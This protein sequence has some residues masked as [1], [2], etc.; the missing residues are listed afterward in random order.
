MTHGFVNTKT[1]E[2]FIFR[3]LILCRVNL[4]DFKRHS[5]SS[6][7]ILYSIAYVNDVFIF[8]YYNIKN[9]SSIMTL[10]LKNNKVKH[11]KQAE[12]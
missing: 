5:P 7:S 4:F 11:F 9:V 8:L 10:V 1:T 12:Q 6:R 3:G 2:I